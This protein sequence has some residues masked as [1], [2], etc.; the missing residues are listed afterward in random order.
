[1]KDNYGN[2]VNVGDKVAYVYTCGRN[3]TC[4]MTGTV[5]KIEKYAGRECAT[6]K[7]EENPVGLSKRLSIYH[8]H[9]TTVTG[10]KILKLV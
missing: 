7:F 10:Q 9:N 5:D 1:M 4:L 8:G 6:I 2:D 3:S